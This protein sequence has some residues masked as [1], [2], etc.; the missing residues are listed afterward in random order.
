M[1]PATRYE[2]ILKDTKNILNNPTPFRFALAGD[3]GRC[4]RLVFEDM[5][6]AGVVPDIV[7]F[8][9]LVKAC[10]QTQNLDEALRIV[11]V[12]FF[13]KILKILFPVS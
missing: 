9:S 12:S 4:K 5:P 10:A 6:R 3:L 7:T 1:F 13:M 11:G 2:K 8:N